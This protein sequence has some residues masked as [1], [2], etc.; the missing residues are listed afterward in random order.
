MAGAALYY[1]HVDLYTD[2]AGILGYNMQFRDN[3]GFEIDLSAGKSK[4]A[5]KLLHVL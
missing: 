5:E 4:D 1:E 3:W 2:R